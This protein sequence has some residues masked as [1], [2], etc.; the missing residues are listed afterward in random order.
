MMRWACR[1]GLL[2]TLFL[3]ACG[4]SKGDIL[5]KAEGIRSK[6]ALEKALGTPSEVNKVG[7]LEQWTYKA[8]DGTVTFTIVGDQVA[9]EHTGSAKQ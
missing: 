6:A 9:L 3:A 5:K 7:P 8:S 1:C 2:L 4:G